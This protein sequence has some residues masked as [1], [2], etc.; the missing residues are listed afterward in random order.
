M[1][2]FPDVQ[3]SSAVGYVRGWSAVPLDAGA[4][5]FCQ[6]TAN[7]ITARHRLGLD[8]SELAIAARAFAERFV[9]L[10]VNVSKSEQQDRTERMFGK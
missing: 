5:G 2:I 10:H 7:R 4:A 6:I 1:M 3:G 9:S 8:N